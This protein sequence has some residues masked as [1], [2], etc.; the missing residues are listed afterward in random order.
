MNVI[1]YIEDDMEYNIKDI[2][3]ISVNNFYYCYYNIACF[4]DNYYLKYLFDECDNNYQFF[5][6]KYISYERMKKDGQ[7]YCNKV[8]NA[9]DVEMVDY[10]GYKV[11][12]NDVFIFY[13]IKEK[14][15]TTIHN[16]TFGTVYDILN[17][18]NI[19]GVSINKKI[20][21]LIKYNNNFCFLSATNN[22]EI[23][24]IPI[25]FYKN[26]SSSEINFTRYFGPKRER[27]KKYIK[28]NQNYKKE[29][30]YNCRFLVF[31]NNISVE[32]ENNA[33]ICFNAEKNVAYLYISGI[34]ILYFDNIY[35]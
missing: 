3:E 23:Y 16:Y 30:N 5:G 6:G 4:K 32:N 7:H 12:D 15:N 1:N 2:N 29:S 21:K 18:Q 9:L 11:F 14:I 10:I 17:K 26:I 31:S 33:E 13:E 20:I 22:E 8:K 19:F 25:T 27:E 35:I 28:L 24:C 34:N